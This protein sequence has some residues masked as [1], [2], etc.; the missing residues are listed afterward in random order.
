MKL[1]KE[2]TVTRTEVMRRDCFRTTLFSFSDRFPRVPRPPLNPARL[3]AH[4]RLRRPAARGTG[5]GKTPAFSSL[6]AAGE[7]SRERIREGPVSRGKSRLIHVS[8]V[9]ARLPRRFPT[10][11]PCPARPNAPSGGSP[12][13]G[14]G[15]TC[16]L[17]DPPEHRPATDQAPHGGS[18]AAPARASTPRPRSAVPIWGSRSLT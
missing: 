3:R 16:H 12:F 11:S 13:P 7:S 15:P 5:T 1:K 2:T 4:P 6:L 14:A 9:L 8:L 10:P 17:S 18:R